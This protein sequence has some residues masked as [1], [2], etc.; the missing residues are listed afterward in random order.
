MPSVGSLLAAVIRI[1]F[2][3]QNVR[4]KRGNNWHRQRRTVLCCTLFYLVVVC[5]THATKIPALSG[6]ICLEETHTCARPKKSFA[7]FGICKVSQQY[8]H[9]V[10]A[11]PQGG[12]PFA[13][14]FEPLWLE[15][16]RLSEAK[17]GECIAQPAAAGSLS[18]SQLLHSQ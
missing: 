3:L 7:R 6:Q 18:L 4:D 13:A 14:I 15:S 17:R 16:R 1:H 10:L 11:W 2:A 9:T 5:R 8:T 12:N